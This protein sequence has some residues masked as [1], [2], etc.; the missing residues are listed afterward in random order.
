MLSICIFSRSHKKVDDRIVNNEIKLDH[1][2]SSRDTHFI[3]AANLFCR[4][5]EEPMSNIL[6]EYLLIK[7]NEVIRMIDLRVQQ[8]ESLDEKQYLQQYRQE[9]L[10]AL[11]DKE[12]D[13]KLSL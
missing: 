5:R 10:S 1:E 3:N 7:I 13:N 11:N 8:S 12:Q 9:F 6:R 4:I 2:I